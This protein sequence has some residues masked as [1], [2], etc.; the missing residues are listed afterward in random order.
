[1]VLGVVRCSSQ[2]R[3]GGKTC[4][5]HVGEFVGLPRLACHHW[6]GCFLTGKAQIEICEIRTLATF[7]QGLCGAL[8]LLAS[9]AWEHLHK[10]RKGCAALYARALFKLCSEQHII[11]WGEIVSCPKD[12]TE[13]FGQV[14]LIVLLFSLCAVFASPATVTLQETGGTL[15][16]CD[17]FREL[18]GKWM[19]GFQWKQTK[20]N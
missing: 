9:P 6:L 18:A 3:P 14:H 17:E 20:M 5:F 4:G 11:G 10:H 15:F 12:D 8:K 16:F 19:T 1:M 2:G 7:I 13:V